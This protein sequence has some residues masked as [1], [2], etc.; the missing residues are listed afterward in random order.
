M[1]DIVIRIIEFIRELLEEDWIY[2][3]ALLKRDFKY[4]VTMYCIETGLEL[5]E[6]EIENLAKKV[7][8]YYRRSG[9]LVT[10]S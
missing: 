9:L 5:T 4:F 3:Q 2:T 7:E 10:S 6:E 1:E 8:E